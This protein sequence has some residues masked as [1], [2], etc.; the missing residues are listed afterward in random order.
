MA[1][2]LHCV[3]FRVA[4]ELP[5]ALLRDEK[6]EILAR[7]SAYKRE[8]SLGMKR[9][10]ITVIVVIIGLFSESLPV[11][12][13]NRLTVCGGCPPGFAQIG[14][15]YS[16]DCGTG[17]GIGQHNASICQRIAVQRS[18]TVCG[19]CPPGFATVGVTH[20]IDCPSGIGLGQ[21][22]ASICRQV[23]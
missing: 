14:V 22:N 18:M 11:K 2:S 23:R 16:L 17:I 19:P 7:S 5:Y 13:Q 20:Q 10:F 12:A 1:F 4:T 21:N 3:G 6:R 15:T 8:G 9:I